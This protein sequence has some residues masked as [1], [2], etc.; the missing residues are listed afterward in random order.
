M[1]YKILIIILI[2]LLS[3]SCFHEDKFENSRKGNFDALWHILDERYCFFDYKEIDWDEVYARYSPRIKEEMSKEALFDVMKE[4]L[5]ELKDGHVNLGSAFDVTRYEDWYADY[6]KNFDIDIIESDRYLGRDYKIASGLKYK[7][8]M[9]NIGYVYYGSFSSGIGT[10]NLHEVISKM[11]TCDGIII[12]VRNNGGGQLSNS[13]TF[14]SGFLK[15]ETLVGYMLHKT[16][17]GH[18][19]FSEPY[20]IKVK[21]Y[22]GYAYMKKVVVLTNRRCYSAANDFVSAM[23]YAPNVVIMGDWTG[24]G[25]GMPFTSELPN[26]WSIRFSA[27]P[28]LNADMEHIEFGV[29]PDIEVNMSDEDKEKGLDTIIEQARSYIKERY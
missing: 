29:E 7:V 14:I 9:D 28:R 15:E 4:M 11:L 16:G 20:A 18:N 12:D 10:G 25:G 3:F 2:G 22:E 27:S 5:A 24:G 13:E 17:K 19:D 1:K 21:P 8:L 23:K 26:G 6:P